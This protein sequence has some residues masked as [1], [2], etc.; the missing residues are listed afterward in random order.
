MVVISLT[1]LQMF[2]LWRTSETELTLTFFAF[3]HGTLLHSFF[4]KIS[5]LNSRFMIDSLTWLP[6]NWKRDFEIKRFM[7]TELNTADPTVTRNVRS[8]GHDPHEGSR[9]SRNFV[10]F[11]RRYD[12]L[13]SP[14]SITWNS[15]MDGGSFQHCIESNN[16][17]AK[18]RKARNARKQEKNIK[19]RNQILFLVDPES[20]VLSEKESCVWRK[21]KCFSKVLDPS[22]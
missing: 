3:I 4:L 14:I 13:T 20:R 18:T 17:V 9:W 16:Y 10:K 2:T 8:Q 11:C 19:I 6:F 15:I 7:S 21:L 1:Q 22:L 5:W 12:F